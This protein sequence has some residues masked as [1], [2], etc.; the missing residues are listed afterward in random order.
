MEIPAY[1]FS[2]RRH[3]RI[4]HPELAPRQGGKM[5][6]CVNCGSEMKGR[7]CEACGA[8]E[9][10]QGGGLATSR[11]M[12]PSLVG[13][14]IMDRYADAYRVSATLVG[15]GNTVK[16]GGLVIAGLIFL[17]GIRGGGFGT[18]AALPFAVVIGGGG[19][20]AGTLLAAVG[21]IHRATLD[22]A[23]NT[24]PFMDDAQRA[25]VMS[26]SPVPSRN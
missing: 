10:G 2:L 21:Q 15:L 22:G 12:P 19:F 20:V 1:R 26:I 14:N 8:Q 11:P 4:A 17:M 23:V 3:N 25:Q 7:F 16:I 5:A 9:S 13:G 18:I 6:F 24:S